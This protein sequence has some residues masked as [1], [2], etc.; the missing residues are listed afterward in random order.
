VVYIH[1]H[2]DEFL[3]DFYDYD[4]GERVTPGIL[5]PVIFKLD[6]LEILRISNIVV[7]GNLLPPGIEQLGNLQVLRLDYCEEIS[8]LPWDNIGTLPKLRE[9]HISNKCS[10]SIPD[11]VFP[12]LAKSKN[13]TTLKICNEDL[14]CIPPSIGIVG[15]TLRHLEIGITTKE[16]QNNPPVRSLGMCQN[17]DFLKVPAKVFVKH[18]PHSFFVRGNKLKELHL[19]WDMFQ[20]RQVAGDDRDDEQWNDDDD[21]EEEDEEE[22]GDNEEAFFSY[23]YGD[24]EDFNAK[25]VDSFSKCQ[26]LKYT[27]KL[28]IVA[29]GNLEPNHLCRNHDLLPM[30]PWKLITYFSSAQ[31]LCELKIEC[32]FLLYLPY[33]LLQI[34]SSLKNLVKVTLMRCAV[35]NYGTDDNISRLSDGNADHANKDISFPHLK[36]FIFIG[37]FFSKET[38]LDLLRLQLPLLERFSFCD[39]E[40][41]SRPRPMDSLRLDDKGLEKL[42]TDLLA[43]CPELKHLD[44]SF[45]DIS[46]INDSI[47]TCLAPKLRCIDLSN[48]PIM[49]QNPPNRCLTRLVQHY[50]QLGY[51]GGESGIE[52]VAYLLSLNRARSRISLAEQPAPLALWPLILENPK[53]AFLRYAL[54]PDDYN[55][56]PT[57][58][59]GPDDPTAIFDLIREIG[60]D[61][62]FSFRLDDKGTTSSKTNDKKSPLRRLD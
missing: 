58:W 44:F 14:V 17:L 23:A 9:L 47:L 35:L 51:L 45:N 32:G 33:D 25:L 2:F 8:N 56:Y 61:K 13:F 16:L 10:G 57:R 11:K 15:K 38:G 27:E 54:V 53:R 37:G 55:W 28:T 60:I 7:G 36:K 26:N 6:A 20:K 40:P 1:L 48:N 29:P 49:D 41:I 3:D 62:I 50:K 39:C 43:R 59:C 46:N 18:F 19:L 31:S 21:E 5:S 4:S 24:Q 22:D 42:C 12:A 52:S 30:I 34:F